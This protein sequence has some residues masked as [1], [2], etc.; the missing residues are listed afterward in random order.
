[1]KVHIAKLN[2]PHWLLFTYPSRYAIHVCTEPLHAI[3]VATLSVHAF[4]CHV[5]LPL[6]WLSRWFVFRAILRHGLPILIHT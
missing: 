6:R 3:I 5:C 1:M 4:S 2:C